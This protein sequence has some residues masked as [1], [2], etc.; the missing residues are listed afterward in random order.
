[1]TKGKKILIQLVAATAGVFLMVYAVVLFNGHLLMEL[2]IGSRMIL[3]MLSQWLL[4]LVPG[5]L[6]WRGRE[7][8][9][10]LGFRKDNLLKQMAIG[11]FL[12]LATSL[13]FTVLP[14]LL[15]FE[16][17]VGSTGY[18]KPW[19][20]LYEFIYTIFGV[21]L[22]EELIFRG[23]LFHKLLATELGQNKS[24]SDLISPLRTFSYIQRQYPSGDYDCS[25]WNPLLCAT[26]KSS[27]L[28]HTL[29]DYSSWYVRCADRSVAVSSVG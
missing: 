21:A 11:I 13:V 17:M 24:D 20:F 1:M 16:D 26:G 14:I 18:T 22:V 6:M 19:Q 5:I 12:A 29:A 15:G 3:M 4:F 8:I 25:D 2:S 10:D 7:S 9:M 27:L 23:Y 28:H